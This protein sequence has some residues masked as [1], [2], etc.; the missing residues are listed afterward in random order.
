MQSVWGDEYDA[1]YVSGAP[2]TGSHDHAAYNGDAHFTEMIEVWTD[3]WAA[4]LHTVP[5]GPFTDAAID[6]R[7]TYDNVLLHYVQ[8][9]AYIGK[10]Q[11]IGEKGRPD[12]P[13]PDNDSDVTGVMQEIKQ[14]YAS[15]ALSDQNLYRAYYDNLMHVAEDAR[16]LIESSDRHMVITSDHGE[17]W[18][19]TSG[20]N[21]N[22]AHVRQVL[23]FKVI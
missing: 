20:H 15:G 6:T 3:N 22:C 16:P 18:S 23:W 10:P 7:V 12:V 9:H 14:A 1:C 8:P 21:H 17:C 13:V 11:I 19:S 2:L 4:D 5:P